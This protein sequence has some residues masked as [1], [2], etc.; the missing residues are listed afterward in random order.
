MV[1]IRAV[2]STSLS[3]ISEGCLNYDVTGDN[4]VLYLSYLILRDIRR[5]EESKFHL[6]MCIAMFF[7]PLFFLIGFDR[8]ENEINCTIYSLLIQY[9][10]MSSVSWMGAEAVLM[11][12]KLI[13]VFG[14]LHLVL[15]SIVAWGMELHNRMA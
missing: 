5:Q 13:I 11:F 3:G 6:Q 10:T 7:M 4:L 14:R 9:F 12:H 15:I 1:I 8:T 2:I